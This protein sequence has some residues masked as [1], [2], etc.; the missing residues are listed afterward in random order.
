ML[1]SSHVAANEAS[2]SLCGKISGSAKM[3][4]REEALKILYGRP[5]VE[6]C[7]SKKQER[8]M[9]RRILLHCF[10]VFLLIIQYGCA[11]SSPIDFFNLVQTGDPKQVLAAIKKG[12][13]VNKSNSGGETP[14]MLA[15]E[16]NSNP[17]VIRILTAS[18][19]NVNARNPAGVTAL[20]FAS[21]NNSN[22]EV[23]RA[24]IEA[25]SDVNARDN[26]GETPL[27]LAVLRDKDFE[28]IIVLLKAGADANA[29]DF[30]FGESVISWARE[31]KKLI[32][33]EA[34]NELENA[35]KP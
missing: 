13:D 1:E 30:V 33:S 27:M 10:I 24:L 8:L 7:R 28:V 12:A 4:N 20:M 25:K 5:S 19:A 18:G 9:N 23:S 34:F 26:A 22:A 17:D 14:L 15:A 6:R 32:K 3:R 2:N 35:L 29:K 16:K 21:R 31:N 11:H